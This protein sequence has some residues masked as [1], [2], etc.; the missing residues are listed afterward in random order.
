MDTEYKAAVKA[1]VG[2]EFLEQ[3]QR[4]KAAAADRKTDCIIAKCREAGFNII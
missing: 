4:R 3:K 1:A 2:A